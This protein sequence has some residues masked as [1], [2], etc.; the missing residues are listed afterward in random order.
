MPVVPF[1]PLIVGAAASVAG[2]ALAGHGK[3][4]T[5]QTSTQTFDPIA[6]AARQQA[7]SAI[8]K[9]LSNPLSLDPGLLS[10]GLTGINSSFNSAVPAMQ[11]IFSSRGLG[12]SGLFGGSLNNAALSRLGQI[13]QLYQ[14]VLSTADARNRA[15]IQQAM[16][17]GS[18]TGTTGTSVSTGP[19]AIAGVG[20]GLQ[21]VGS[22]LALLSALKGGIPGASPGSNPATPA[23]P[24]PVIPGTGQA[25]IAPM[26]G[27]DVNTSGLMGAGW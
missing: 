21:N 7:G 20:G 10:Q 12:Q 8:T 4:T 24:F 27:L 22:L 23:M 19:G 15:N 25:P 14:Q 11:D 1:I 2:S 6:A 17:L 3:T 13:G 16:Q 26:P 18:P 9:E 5:N